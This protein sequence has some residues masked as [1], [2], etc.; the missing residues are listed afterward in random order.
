MGTYV[1]TESHVCNLTPGISKCKYGLSENAVL[2][3]SNSRGELKV[4][5]PMVGD[6]HSDIINDPPD[7]V[8][9]VPYNS[10]NLSAELSVGELKTGGFTAYMKNTGASASYFKVMYLA[11]WN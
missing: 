4:I 8:I 6:D 9:A 10:S 2:I 3:D 7:V 1:K 11:I 5:I